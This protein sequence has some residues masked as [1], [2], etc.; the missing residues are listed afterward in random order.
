[1]VIDENVVDELY[2]ILRSSK[3][4]RTRRNVITS[5]LSA[6]LDKC[7]ISDHDAVHLLPAIAESFQVCSSK[8]TINRT[9]IKKE[10]EHIREQISETIKSTFLNLN[11]NFVVILGVTSRF[12]K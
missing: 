9:S 5:H 7:K 1:M 8:F 2:N 12:I 3:L 10:R 6:T 11:L 4:K